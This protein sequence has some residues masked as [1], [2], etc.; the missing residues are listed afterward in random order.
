VKPFGVALIGALFAWPLLQAYRRG[1]AARPLQRWQDQPW[2]ARWPHVTVIIPAWEENGTLEACL[3]RVSK[4]DYPN[5]EVILAAGGND[6]TY[7]IAERMSRQNRRFRVIRQRSAGGKNGAMNDAVRQASGEV[8]VFLDAD[9][10]VS[11]FWLKSLVAA[12]G[13]CESSEVYAASTGRV[14]AAQ[15]TLVARVGEM[16]QT[17]EYEARGRV[18]L[19]GSGSMAIWRWAWDRVGAIPEGAYADDWDLNARIHHA[20]MRV[21][22]APTAV[23]WSERPATLAQ[24]W[25]NELR[26]RRIHLTSLIRI[27]RAEMPDTWSAAR[28]LY[29]YLVGWSFVTLASAALAQRLLPARPRLAGSA[30][31]AVTATALARELAGAVETAAYTGNPAWLA[32]A[33]VIPVLTVTGWIASVVATL[34]SR[35][36]PLHFKGPRSR[37]PAWRST[38]S[39]PRSDLPQVNGEEAVAEMIA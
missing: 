28:A 2:P 31:L 9:S 5:Y 18:S 32:A 20:G 7:E 15:R 30:W 25:Q 16:N 23:V 8:L 35:R 22:Y 21:S 36:A 4:L 34:T 29:P 33:P 1:R 14:V 13:N 19:Q 38:E 10:I 11:P 12:L 39:E 26:W 6:G 37:P 27:A 24:W 17:L 3:E